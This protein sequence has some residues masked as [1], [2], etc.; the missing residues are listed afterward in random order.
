MKKLYILI[1]LCFA[2]QS[3]AFGQASTA[4]NVQDEVYEDLDW[5]IA[6]EYINPY[7]KGIMPLSRIQIAKLIGPLLQDIQKSDSQFSKKENIFHEKISRLRAR[8]YNEFVLLGYIQAHKPKIEFQFLDSFLFDTTWI[9]SNPRDY[10]LPQQI[11]GAYNPFLNYQE[12]RSQ[13]PGLQHLI[14]TEHRFRLNHFLAGYFRP[15]FELQF[16]NSLRQADANLSVQELYAGF[17]FLNTDIYIGKKNLQLGQSPNGGVPLTNNAKPFYNFQ[18]SNHKPYN[19]KDYKPHQFAVVAH[20][21]EDCYQ[22]MLY[23]KEN[24]L[25]T[26]ILF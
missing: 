24:Y 16:E 19:I 15:R 7:F 8:F 12:G 17:H 11:D 6:Q 13:N 1:V 22:S 3:L 5:L 9:D 4:I 21:H 10:A 18:M 23:Q 2:F 14:E 20:N 25:K 26:E